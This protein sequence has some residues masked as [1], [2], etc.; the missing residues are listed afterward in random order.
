[1]YKRQVPCLVLENMLFTS[2]AAANTT[3]LGVQGNARVAVTGD[4]AGARVENQRTAFTR[5]TAPIVRCYQMYEVKMHGSQVME[6][7]YLNP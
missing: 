1:M 5:F 3:T 4:A 7:V 2:Y 6:L